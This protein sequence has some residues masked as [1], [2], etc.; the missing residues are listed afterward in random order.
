VIRGSGSGDDAA[1]AVAFDRDDNV[2]MG[3]EVQSFDT[4]T[5]FAVVKLRGADGLPF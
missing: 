2:A 5:D 4:G 1:R 3:G